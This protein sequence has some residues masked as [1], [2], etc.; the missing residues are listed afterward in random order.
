MSTIVTK[1]QFARACNISPARVTQHLKSGKID[2]AA[3]IGSGRGA[4]LDLEVAQAQLKLRLDVDQRYSM[5]GLST[6]LD[7]AAP[8]VRAPTE[9]DIEVEVAY[10]AVVLV[11]VFDAELKRLAEASAHRYDTPPG[12]AHEVFKQEFAEARAE[13]AAVKRI[14]APV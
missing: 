7:G 10:A 1:S 4:R 14:G 12:G 6:R 3:I 8:A 5:N 2:G 11:R 9:T 13:L